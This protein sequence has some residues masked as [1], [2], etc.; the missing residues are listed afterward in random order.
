MTMYKYDRRESNTNDVL[1]FIA[2]A[3]LGIGL[4]MLLAPKAGQETR[5]AIRGKVND[6]KDY[7]ARRG[8]DLTRELANRASTLADKA[9]ELAEKGKEA[10]DKHRSSVAAAVDAGRQ[11]Y[12]ETVS[13]V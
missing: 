5:D 7:L 11:A 4:G 6:G 13:T 1:M 2:G 8:S 12:R 10:V 9:S 3:G